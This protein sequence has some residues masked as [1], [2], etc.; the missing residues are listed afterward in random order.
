MD[1]IGYKVD[2]ISH[3]AWFEHVD[4]TDG[5]ATVIGCPKEALR[6]YFKTI[7]GHEY[8]II[9]KGSEYVDKDEM[10]S[11]VDKKCK[12]VIVGTC[13]ILGVD[14]STARSLTPEECDQL[15]NTATFSISDGSV[16][17]EA[18]RVD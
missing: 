13:V 11:V 9:A 18:V 8:M 17:S 3:T 7:E 5:C 16:E 1:M 15:Y 4:G 2:T 12:G 6:S 10:A 14:K